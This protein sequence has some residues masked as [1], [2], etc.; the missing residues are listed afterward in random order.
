MAGSA[1]D[2]VLAGSLCEEGAVSLEGRGIEPIPE[3]A[4]YGSLARVF[5]VWFTPNLTLSA[6]F[7]GSLATADF[8]RLGF[9]TALLAI[10]VGN[11]LGGLLVGALAAMG[12]ATGMGQIPFA[13]LP[14]GKGIVLPGLL[15]WISTI[16]WDGINSLFG[17]GALVLLV[18]APFPLALLLIVGCQGALGIL[19]YEAI[20]LFERW[21]AP[22]LGG[23]FVVLTVAIAGQADV[24]RVDGFSGLDDL[25]AFVLMVSIVVSYMLGWAL[26]ASDYTRYLPASTSAR[27]VGVA[28]AASLIVSTSWIEILGL[29][30]ADQLRD[31]TVSGVDRLLGG[32]V[33]GAIALVAIAVGTVASNALN[34]YTGSLSLQAAGVRVP[35]ALAAA[36]VAV[37]GFLF[38]LYLNAGSFASEY[39]NYL[40]FLSYWIAPAA[41]VILADWWLRGRTADPR[42]LV[43]FSRLSGGLPALAALA[44]G[45]LVSLPFQASSIG[46]DI[47]ASTGL[48]VNAISAGPLH[49]ADL[50]YLVGLAVAVAVYLGAW[51]LAPGSRSASPMAPRS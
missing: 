15:N 14:F 39:E 31:S 48:P 5:T 50:G 45:F 9:G 22:A 38:T 13:R 1:V 44:A 36:I 43:T 25:G 4:R 28:T 37:L 23:L 29:L 32:G 40:L 33:V 30:V 34:D 42:D 6:F 46:A 20:H 49:G 47:A 17:A 3:S 2:G 18:G 16:G 26:Y 12:P 51:R 35:R 7:I 27:A 19:G 8:L 41:G 24:T 11:L 10:I 21:L